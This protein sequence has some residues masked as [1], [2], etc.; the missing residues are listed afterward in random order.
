[1]KVQVRHQNGK[2]YPHDLSHD[3]NTTSSFGFC[4]PILSR[5]LNAQDTVSLRFGQICRLNPLAKPAFANMKVKTYT[6]FVKAE[7]IWHAYGSFLSGQTYG[8]A[9]NSYIPSYLPSTSCRSLY[10]LLMCLSDCEIVDGTFSTS[11][12]GSLVGTHFSISTV[13]RGERRAQLLN[14][15]VEYGGFKTIDDAGIGWDTFEQAIADRFGTESR[16]PK[17]LFDKAGISSV[18]ELQNMDWYVTVSEGVSQPFMVTGRF[19]NLA[20]NLRKVFIGN[21]YQLNFDSTRVDALPLFSNFKAYFDIFVPQ[22]NITWKDTDAFKLM[23]YCEQS[24]LND[25]RDFSNMITDGH[26][27]SYIDFIL[28]L[29]TMY[30]TIPG[31]YASAHILGLGNDVVSNSSFNYL[32]NNDTVKSVSSFSQDGAEVHGSVALKDY[33]DSENLT[34]SSL[35]ILNEMQKLKNLHSAVGGNIREFLRAVYNSDYNDDVDSAFIGSQILDISPNPVF[36]TAET[37]S[38]ALGEFGGA[39]LGRTDGKTLKFTAKSP[40]YLVSFFCIVPESRMSQGVD[41]LLYH[42]VKEDIFNPVYDALTL[43]PTRKTCIYGVEEMSTSGSLLT[44]GFGNIPNFS[45]YKIKHNILNGDMSLPSTRAT[46]LPFTLDKLLPYRKIEFNQQTT[47][48]VI[49]PGVQNTSLVAGTFWRYIGLYRWF[50]NFD[51]I[52]VYDEF[53]EKEQALKYDFFAS[54]D[55]N[56]NL[57]MYADFKVTGYELPLARSFDTGEMDGDTMTVEKS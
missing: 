27:R 34:R 6:S 4:Q 18:S 11:S 26:F 3:I 22:R 5:Q 2:K 7:D 45:E 10:F 55:D 54:Y 41:P 17:S 48:L 42:Q 39:A 40:G 50:G 38:A 32:S 49:S 53:S 24:G 51:R 33:V 56:F 47:G 8:G 46:Y 44:G 13:S 20:R 43:L 15:L 52:F 21:G 30:Y 14:L 57:S 16:D 37:E 19:N 36:N 25:F 29:A 31:D 28:D 23:E 9:I 35:R 1:M 12:D